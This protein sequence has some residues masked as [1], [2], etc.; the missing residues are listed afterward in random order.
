MKGLLRRI[1]RYVKSVQDA[2][3]GS[4]MIILFDLHIQMLWSSHLLCALAAP[5]N[6]GT[7][8]SPN[9]NLPLMISVALGN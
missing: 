6:H 5:Y 9:M 2:A 4:I 7:T 8:R 1:P 3:G